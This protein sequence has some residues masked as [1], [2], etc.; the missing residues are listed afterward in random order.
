MLNMKKM[1]HGLPYLKDPI[2]LCDECCNA[3]Q[4]RSS[5]KHDLPMKFK[6]TME[7]VHFDV[8]GSFEVR[9]NVGN[10][11][12]LTFIEEFTRHVW[13]YLIERKS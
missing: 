13:V 12:F 2:H 3:K 4:A 7:L 8:C 1:E 10:C 11:Y 9:S 5:F 6:K